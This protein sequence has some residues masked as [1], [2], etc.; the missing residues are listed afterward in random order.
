MSEKQEEAENSLTVEL[1]KEEAALVFGAEGVQ[2]Y[3]PKLND[4][5]EVPFYIGIAA[6]VALRVVKDESFGKE[7]LDWL[8]KEQLEML[9]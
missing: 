7:M 3:S 1:K 9:K 2:F 4:E 5:D 6:A 8:S